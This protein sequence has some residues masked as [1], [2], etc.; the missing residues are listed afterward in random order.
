[1]ARM[2]TEIY[3]DADG[4]SRWRVVADNNEIVGASSEGF[5]NDATA[6]ANMILLQQGIAQWMT[7]GVGIQVLSELADL[8]TD[9]L[10]PDASVITKLLE[11]V[12]PDDRVQWLRAIDMCHGCG[13]IPYDGCRCEDDS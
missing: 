10:L 13:K 8:R 2:K 3:K 12:D 7:D 11:D 9:G 4:Q 1:M 5:A 6:R